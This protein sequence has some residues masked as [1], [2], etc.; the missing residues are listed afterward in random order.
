M[1]TLRCGSPD[2]V[3]FSA[4]GLAAFDKLVRGSLGHAFPA[5][6]VLVARRGIVA[7]HQA[8]GYLDPGRERRP[9]PADAVFD[10][11]SLTKLFTATAFM[12]LVEAGRVTLSAPV[13]DV[14]P[15]A[16]TC[17]E[18]SPAVLE[19]V[20]HPESSAN[21]SPDPAPCGTDPRDFY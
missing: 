8:Y 15:N 17:A 10:L 14:V 2:D 13:A 5:A 3:A 19:S 7:F 9:T 12:R 20:R 4:G 21:H 18:R 11:A 6:V 1:S 16:V